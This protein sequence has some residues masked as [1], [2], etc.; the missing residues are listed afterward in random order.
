MMAIF[1]KKELKLAERTQMAFMQMYQAGY[2][3]GAGWK[4]RKGHVSEKR[5]KEVAQAF[6]KRFFKKENGR[7]E[8]P[9]NAKRKPTRRKAK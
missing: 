7:N 8:Q 3:D 4:L 2:I 9:T 5:K 6:K 1:K